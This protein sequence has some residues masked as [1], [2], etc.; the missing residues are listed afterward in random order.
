MIA[1]TQQWV[2]DM[3]VEADDSS[4]QYSTNGTT[5][6]F[7]VPF[8]FLANTHLQVV[9]TTAAGVSSTLAL[10]TDYTVSGA[11]NSSGGSITTTV[12]YA[13]DGGT[14]SIVRDVPATQVTDYVAGDA[15][16]ADAHERALDKLTMIAQQQREVLTR[17]LVVPVG[18]APVSAIPRA[19]DRAGRIHAYDASGNPIAIAGADSDSAADLALD[20]A[21]S[22][23]S[24]G[25]ALIGWLR[26]ATS[27]VATT[28]YRWMGWQ[29]LSVFEF[30]T[31]AQI[32][33]VQA[34]TYGIDVSAPVQAAL[35]AARAS[36]KRLLFPPGGYRVNSLAI[37]ETG[38]EAGK[39]LWIEGAGIGNPF[40][41]DSANGVV[42]KGSAN[43]PI[44]AVYT[45][46][47]STSTGTLKIKGIS[48]VGNSTTPVVYLESLYGTSEVCDVVIRQDGVG[49]G[50]QV[51]VMATASI[52]DCYFLNRDLV[53][54][55][56]GAAR[57]GVGL[58]IN[59]L[60]DAGLQTVYKCSSRGFLTG[61][62]IGALTGSAYCYSASLYDSEC[63]AV[64]NGVHLT[65]L[66]RGTRV[67]NIYCEGGEGGVAL[68]DEGDNNTISRCYTFPGFSV[69]LKSTSFTYG[70]VYEGNTLLAGTEANQ[71]L[72]DV[73]SSGAS[74]GPQKVVTN[75][76]LSFGGSGGSIAGVIG[77][78]IN[79]SDPRLHMSGNSFFPRGAWTGGAGTLKVSDLSASTDTTAGS[80]LYGLRTLLS[81]SWAL[82]V[83]ALGRGA[84]N[85]AVEPV[86]LNNTNIAAGVL[87]V[88]ELSVFTLTPTAN[89]AIT[90]IASPNL[91]DK[92]FSIHVTATAFT[93]TF[94]HGALLKLT[95]SANIA[96]GASGAWLTFQIKAGGVAW[97]TSHIA[98]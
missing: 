95:G 12:A 69:H 94:T 26:A 36:G 85:L 4:A 45:S 71:V 15:F 1:P 38:A 61:F 86:V 74:G 77:L 83:P 82:E 97:L 49:N 10:N 90:S 60:Y 88:G 73:T 25:T 52:H 57:V 65:A 6:P 68:W 55:G 72:I 70:G 41:A 3:T 79:G 31:S 64:Y 62:Q 91:P 93:V 43:D 92:T 56:L 81:S 29:D 40:T 23:S 66:A 59:Q 21:S 24:K 32:A 51:D 84:V 33:D 44:L 48:F 7:T 47:V 98:Y 39:V 89:V 22:N 16:P 76:H 18:E 54:F 46:A 20:L 53:T 87:T 63:S 19:A 8:Y 96:T 13:N 14:L 30:M 75:N 11:G 50:M 37:Y 58:V 27:A 9:Y 5:G 2:R 42:L 78:R 80:G 17:A 67:D 28:L 35:N 34:Y